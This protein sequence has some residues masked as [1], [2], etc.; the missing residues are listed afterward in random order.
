MSTTAGHHI[1]KPQYVNWG[2]MPR[3]EMVLGTMITKEI[4]NFQKFCEAVQSIGRYL[5]HS[6]MDYGITAVHS[7]LLTYIP[8]NIYT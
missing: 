6:A 8:R 5:L 2:D 3:K 4:I 7:Y 1:F